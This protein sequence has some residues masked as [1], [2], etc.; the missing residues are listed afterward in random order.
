MGVKAVTEFLARRKRVGV[1]T[2]IFIYYL[3]DHPTYSLLVRP[4]FEA[5]E[6][7]KIVG[8]TSVITLMEIL[9]HP[10]RSGNVIAARDYQ[11]LLLA[12][13]NLIV[14]E[15]DKETVDLA[16]DLQ[17]KYGIRTPDA[18]QLA[19]AVQGGASGFITK[20]THLRQVEEGIEI[21]LLDDL[22]DRR[23]RRAL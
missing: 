2:M 1:D 13:P 21:I 3:E 4:L 10:K 12:Y 5:L 23:Q 6:S 11:D 22:I 16:S 19:A 15:I 8:V 20:D 14:A 7:G 18:L 17:A 9:V